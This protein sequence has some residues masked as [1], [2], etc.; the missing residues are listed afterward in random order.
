MKR[1]AAYHLDGLPGLSREARDTLLKKQPRTVLGALQIPGVGR[2]TTKALRE[3]GVLTDPDGVQDQGRTLV[4]MKVPQRPKRS[5]APT[6]QLVEPLP[7][8]DDYVLRIFLGGVGRQADFALMAAR[9]LVSAA[10]LGGNGD[11]DMQRVWYSA[12]AFF[13]SVANV[14]KLIWPT[15][16]KGEQRLADRGERLQEI[17]DADT[18]GVL[19][20]K[21]L[22]NDLEHFDARLEAWATTV[23]GR[24]FIDGNINAHL[25]LR[26]IPQERWLRNL[27]TQK[28]TITF[29]GK[30]HALKPVLEAIQVL[31]NRVVAALAGQGRVPVATSKPRQ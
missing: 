1:I 23:D 14:S 12:Q 15:Y 9:D 29:R 22:R 10:G 30:E 31:R 21:D 13:A 20:S 19:R 7:P 11:A 16:R 24:P 5:A 18:L 17:L 4:E 3:L 25:A 6:P 28:M 26:D 27:D 2:K 8:C